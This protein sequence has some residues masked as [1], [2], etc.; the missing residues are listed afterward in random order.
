MRVNAP[1]TVGLKLEIVILCALT[2]VKILEL[3]YCFA[4]CLLQQTIIIMTRR[5]NIQTP[6]CFPKTVTI[7]KNINLFNFSRA[8]AYNM[9]LVKF[10]LRSY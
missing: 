2:T 7:R 4:R 9:E 5:K 8:T 1:N 10:K 3:N 6:T